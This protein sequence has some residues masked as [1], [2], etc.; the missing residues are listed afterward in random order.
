MTELELNN[1][2]DNMSEKYGVNFYEKLANSDF[3]YLLNKN[4]EEQNDFWECCPS[5][6]LFEK[7]S[8]R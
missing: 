6:L 3:Q 4:S 8:K 2:I 1:L 7:R 5:I